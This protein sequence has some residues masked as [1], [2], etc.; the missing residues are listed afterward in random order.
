MRGVAAERASDSNLLM[1]ASADGKS[2]ATRCSATMRASM[3]WRRNVRFSCTAHA[4]CSRHTSSCAAHGS[5]CVRRPPVCQT[6]SC[7]SDELLES[8]VLL[9]DP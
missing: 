8:H 4:T 6:N 5:L 2:L 3:R 7:V 9:A 1:R